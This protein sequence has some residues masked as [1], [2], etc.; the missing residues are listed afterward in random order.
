MIGVLLYKNVG[1]LF[2]QKF[3]ASELNSAR[4]I[5]LI[6]VVNVAIAFPL[7]VF[8][9]YI[10]SSEKFA[11]QKGLLT[12]KAILYPISLIYALFNGANAIVVVILMSAFNLA[13]NLINAYYCIVKL[14]MRFKISKSCLKYFKENQKSRSCCGERR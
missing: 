10:I 14:D 6:L 4:I 11:F 3:T 13:I 1:L 12:V 8:G 5:I 9:S 7:S 2:G